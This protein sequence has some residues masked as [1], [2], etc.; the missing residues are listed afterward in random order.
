MFLSEA[1][2]SAFQSQKEWNTINVQGWILKFKKL[3][4]LYSS[5]SSTSES[6]ETLTA[7]VPQGRILLRRLPQPEVEVTFGTGKG[8]SSFCHQ[9]PELFIY[10]FPFLSFILVYWIWVCCGFK[11]LF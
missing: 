1:L 11:N 8:H 3:D 5:D 10:L 4:C 2:I 9:R 6:Q 7:A